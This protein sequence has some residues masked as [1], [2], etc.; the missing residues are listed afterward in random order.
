MKYVNEPLRPTRKLDPAIPKEIDALIVKLLAKDPANRPGS[1]SKLL[2]DVD[3]VWE[4]L[5]LPRLPNP[6]P[7]PNQNRIR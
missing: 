1:A 3:R 2:A 6:R 7:R 5:P 4:G